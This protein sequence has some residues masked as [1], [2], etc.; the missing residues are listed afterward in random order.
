M[1]LTISP[2]A[3]QAGFDQKTLR[4]APPLKEESANPNVSNHLT[5][6]GLQTDL[7]NLEVIKIIPEEET[8]GDSSFFPN[9]SLMTNKSVLNT[10]SNLDEVVVI[11]IDPE[12]GEDVQK[13]LDK[14]KQSFNYHIRE[15]QKLAFE[16][17]P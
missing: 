12:T 17:L 8:N 13:V 7:S 3:F 1:S 15:Y 16:E 14:N 5:D 9:R 10:D 4:L 2:Q 11:K 6:N